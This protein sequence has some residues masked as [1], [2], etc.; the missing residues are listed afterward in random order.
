M[1][2]GD[3]VKPKDF[4]LEDESP[5]IIVEIKHP[6]TKHPDYRTPTTIKCSFVDERT[7]KSWF[8]RHELEIVL[9]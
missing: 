4:V 1:K 5:G 6:S 7:E 8:Y 2:V 9:G 3:L